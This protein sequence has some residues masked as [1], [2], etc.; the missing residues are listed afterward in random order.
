[1][2]ANVAAK[3]VSMLSEFFAIHLLG[4]AVS[5][6]PYRRTSFNQR[7][8]ALMSGFS[9]AESKLKRPSPTAFLPRGMWQPAGEFHPQIIPVKLSHEN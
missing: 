4:D 3:R 9:A 6:K 2:A 1:M 5:K 7:P 8:S